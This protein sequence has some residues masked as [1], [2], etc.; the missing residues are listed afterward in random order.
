MT[1]TVDEMALLRLAG[2]QG[3]GHPA[4]AFCRDVVAAR[5][6]VRLP[7]RFRNPPSG[8]LYHQ[9]DRHGVAVVAAPTTSL[10]PEAVAGLLRFRLAQYLDIGFI[11]RRLATG[12]GCGR[13]RPRWS[14]RATST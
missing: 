10:P 2:P 7:A 3:D 13:S 4:A 12:S 8:T 5:A 9:R 6:E 14:R 1:S 11:D